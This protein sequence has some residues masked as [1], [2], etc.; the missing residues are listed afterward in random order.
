MG[1][2]AGENTGLADA[3]PRHRRER[4]TILLDFQQDIDEL[5]PT[6]GSYNIFSDPPSDPLRR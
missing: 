1:T 5:P 2:P 6:G 3:A 4:R